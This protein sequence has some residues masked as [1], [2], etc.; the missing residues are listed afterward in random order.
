MFLNMTT[1]LA[2][3]DG[4]AIGSG[5]FSQHRQSHRIRLNRS[6]SGISVAAVASL[7]DSGTVVD[8]YTKENHGMR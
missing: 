8:I 4:D 2:Q 5:S 7:P 3:M 1:V 6:I